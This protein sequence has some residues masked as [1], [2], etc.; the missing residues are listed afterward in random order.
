MLWIT[1]TLFVNIK[2]YVKAPLVFFNHTAAPEMSCDSDTLANNIPWKNSYTL[3]FSTNLKPTDEWEKSSYE[4]A[5]NLYYII[6]LL[7]C[8]SWQ[9]C[10]IWQQILLLLLPFFWSLW[11]FFLSSFTTLVEGHIR[12]KEKILSIIFLYNEATFHWWVD[13][14][15]NQFCF[16]TQSISSRILWLSNQKLHRPDG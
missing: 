2:L 4:T 6:I 14:A 16:L 11:L 9:W 13:F 7:Y 3:I 12:C 8:K 10:E 15:V 5:W 1:I